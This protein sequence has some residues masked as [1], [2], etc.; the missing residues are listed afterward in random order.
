MSLLEV[1][2]TVTARPPWSPWIFNTTTLNSLP[3][4]NTYLVTAVDLDNLRNAIH[5][6]HHAV[7]LVDATLGTL[8][9]Q[10]PHCPYFRR[11]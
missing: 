4:Q 1:M 3:P 6:M 7:V 11:A 2:T 8:R 10:N 9:A 5:F